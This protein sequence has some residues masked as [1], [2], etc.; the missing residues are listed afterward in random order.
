MPDSRS[1][2]PTYPIHVNGF[3][4]C[5]RHRLSKKKKVTLLRNEGKIKKPKYEIKT[6][7]KDNSYDLST[8]EAE[9]GGS[10]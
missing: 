3:C 2:K 4:L 6:F 10:L 1:P 7:V 8:Q 9:P 5:F